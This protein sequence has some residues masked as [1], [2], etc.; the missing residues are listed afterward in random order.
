MNKT[1]KLCLIIFVAALA[2]GGLGAWYAASAID[3]AKLTKL[4][5]TTI[6]EETG[7]DLTISGPVSLSIFPSIGVKA[8]QVTLSNASW[9]S[10]DQ[11]LSVKHLELDVKLFPL[12]SKRVEVSKITLGGVDAH[13]QTNKARQDNWDLS[14]SSSAP[15]SSPAA[16]NSANNASDQSNLVAIETVEITDARISYQNGSSPLKVINIPKLSL[17]GEGGKTAVLLDAQYADYQLGLKGKMSSLRQ[18]I[19][20]WGQSPVHMNLDLTLSLNGKSLDIGGK[21]DKPTKGLPQFDIQLTS[22]SFDLLPL[23]A[24]AAA[25][26]QK[27]ARVV[28]SPSAQSRYFFSDAIL[29]LDAI[30]SADGK[31]QINIAELGVPDQAP[32]KNVSGTV[33]FKGDRL[34]IQDLKFELGRGQAQAQISLSQFHSASPQFTLKGMAN[35]FTLEQ[36]VVSRDPSA[37]MTGGEA[38]VALNLSGRGNSLHQMASTANGAVQLTVGQARLDSKLLNTAGD[39]AVTVMN[40]VNPMRKNNKQAILECA[41]VYLPINNGFINIQDSVGVETD[42]LDI[43]LSG[44][45]NLQSEAINLKIHPQ[46]KTGLTTGVDLG[47][48]VQI[49]GSL[50]NPRAGVNKAGVVNSAVAIG[51]G[52]LTG[53]ISIAAENA[54]SLT[55]KRQPCK[56]AMHPWASIYPGS[57]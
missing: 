33:A 17:I 39:F 54:R 38:Q 48:L 13:L 4:L 30:P 18:A 45:V 10:D 20:D 49:E 15:I 46:D 22:K 27:S 29:P 5:S 53:G 36:I 9:A 16:S 26:G 19:I 47:G 37:K 1:L 52:I 25:S 14:S 32:F 23:A 7:R 44:T 3:P 51:L 11:M 12:F 40:A 55:T 6:K 8:E 43:V 35:N 56:T 57:N 2:L 24:G 34:D 42:R 31:V 41:V 21:I 50:E 28:R